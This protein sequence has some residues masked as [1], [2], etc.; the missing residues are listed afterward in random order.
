MQLVRALVRRTMIQLLVKT[1]LRQSELGIS[2]VRLFFTWWCIHPTNDGIEKPLIISKTMLDALCML[3]MSA[4]NDLKL[5][6]LVC[7]ITHI[8]PDTYAKTYDNIASP[9]LAKSTPTQSISKATR[10]QIDWPASGRVSCG[11][12]QMLMRNKARL[13]AAA[14]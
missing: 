5:V 10:F 12:A 8:D 3:L 11:K 14:R 1:L 4:D 2:A 7:N 6:N 13:A 9:M